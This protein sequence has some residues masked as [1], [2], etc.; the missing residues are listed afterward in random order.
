GQQLFDD[1]VARLRDA[2][3]VL[4]AIEGGF[5]D[6][7]TGRMLQCDGLFVRADRVP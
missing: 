2:G 4:Y 1:L 6:R 5:G 3:Y 7:R